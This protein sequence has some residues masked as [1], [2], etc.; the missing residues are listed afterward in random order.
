MGAVG[1]SKDSGGG[2]DLR[3]A[4]ITGV[5]GGAAITGVS[6]R[7]AITGVS[8]GAAITGVSSGCTGCSV[9]G[10]A[11]LMGMLEVLRFDGLEELRLGLFHKHK[12]YSQAQPSFASFF[13]S[14]TVNK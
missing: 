9:T 7:A 4:A 10:G 12:L 1:C 14:N 5:F 8:S 13:H 6:G 2:L 3:G 11:A